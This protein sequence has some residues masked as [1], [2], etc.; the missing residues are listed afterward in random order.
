MPCAGQDIQLMITADNSFTSELNGVTGQGSDFTTYQ[1]YTIPTSNV[2][3][4]SSF[5]NSGQALVLNVNASNSDQ[6]QGCANNPEGL[7]FAV[8]TADCR[9]CLSGSFYSAQQCGCTSCSTYLTGCATCTSSTSCTSCVSNSY[10]LSGGQCHTCSSI[11][12]GCLTCSSSTVCL[13]C[14]TRIRTIILN[15]FVCTQCSIIMPH[16]HQCSASSRCDT[17]DSGYAPYAS[18]CSLCSSLIVGCQLC[19]SSTVCISC[20]SVNNF[21]L[22]NYLC[23]CNTGY[24]LN[25]TACSLCSGFIVG[26]LSCSSTTV[27]TLCNSTS[28]FILEQGVCHCKPYYALSGSGCLSCGWLMVG[29]DNCSNSTTC[30]TCSGGE[31][32]IS[33]DSSCD[34]SKGYALDGLSCKKCEPGCILCTAQRC[35][36]FCGDGVVNGSDC[37]DGNTKDGDG[38]SSICA[39]EENYTCKTTRP[40]YCSYNK[41]LELGILSVTKADDN[42]TLNIAISVSPLLQDLNS[43]TFRLTVNNSNATAEFGSYSNGTL[44]FTLHY[45]ADISNGSLMLTINANSAEKTY[46]IPNSSVMLEPKPANFPAYYFAPSVYQEVKQYVVVTVMLIVVCLVLSLVDLFLKRKVGME[47]L[48]FLFLRCLIAIVIKPNLFS[49]QL[50][51][52]L[53]VIG[54]S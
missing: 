7:I 27:C 8:T 10:L 1:T 46:A 19:S 47:L 31:H 15:N 45:T 43:T 21:M 26:C 24:V 13:S 30:I 5:N 6:G 38:C 36:D 12:F 41:P 35:T 28:N 3:C 50:R 4:G 32:F 14:D 39:V 52:I 44:T 20:D 11:N 54:F 23:Q 51:K 34:C 9:S 42:N 37:D 25:G 29:C 48:Q 17:C 2:P 49:L 16:C 22:V 33:K 40:Y 18:G 53:Q